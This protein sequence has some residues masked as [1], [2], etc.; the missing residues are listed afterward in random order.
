MEYNLS[1]SNNVD[2]SDIS[3]SKFTDDEK[4]CITDI[5]DKISFDFESISKYGKDATKNLVTLSTQILDMAESTDSAEIDEA[6]T[7]LVSNLNH[8]M[9]QRQSKKGILSVFRKKEELPASPE[10]CKTVYKT[11]YDV[12]AK[13]EQMEYQ[14]QKDIKINE[15]Y[16]AMNLE[17]IREL[18]KY[19]LAAEMR[20][21]EEE[22]D[23]SEKKLTVD[24]NDLLAV[25]E[26]SSREADLKNFEKRI[27]NLRLQRTIAIQNIPQIMLCKE[28]DAVLA[29]KINDA[30]EQTI[31]LWESQMAI[32]RSI[33]KMQEGAAVSKSVSNTTNFL[34]KKNGEVL[35]QGAIGVAEENERAIVDVDTLI[36]VNTS[37]ISTIEGIYEI[38][39]SGEKA[40]DESIQKLAQIQSQLNNAIMQKV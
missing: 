15:R 26:V 19:I 29:S 2:L 25:Q 33:R 10:E 8:S 17:Y 11:I 9:P 37:L 38:R 4:K 40:R 1:L 13:L 5:K 27:Y 21:Q 39:K 35:K 24:K 7:T 34:L 18:E 28:G 14:L 22:Q 6:L 23:I 36:D 20:M 16:H 3:I 12:K 31:P 32:Q 30:I